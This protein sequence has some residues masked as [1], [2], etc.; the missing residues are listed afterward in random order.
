M[1][2]GLGT[3][4]LSRQKHLPGAGA[5]A[6]T[7][8]PVI[9]GTRRLGEELTITP[10]IWTLN[11]VLTYQWRR[12]GVNIDGATGLTYIA[13]MADVGTVIDALEIPNGDTG[14]AAVTNSLVFSAFLD[15]VVPNVEFH[16][17]ATKTASYPGTGQ[18]WAN[19]VAAP[20]SGA[21]QTA[22]DWWLG[23]DVN[24]AAADPTFIGS[25]GDPGAYF[26]LDGGDF[27]RSK[28]ATLP[29]FI[30]NLHKATG[31]QAATYIY[32]WRHADGS[33]KVMLANNTAPGVRGIRLQSTAAE[34]LEF[35]QRGDVANVVH[36]IGAL[37][38]GADYM[39][40]L[41]VPAGGGT[42]RHW[43]NAAAKTETTMTFDTTSSDPVG[44]ILAIGCETDL[45][46]PLPSGTQ[47]YAIAMIAGV[48]DDAEWAKIISYFE[49][50]TVGH[51]RNYVA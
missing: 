35:Q 17:D 39:V 51:N 27:F 22:Y 26:G 23:N 28:A 50:A 6:N 21:A 3:G 14:A 9:S 13:V 33:T 7:S 48:I 8:D 5:P 46:S 24:V 38:N 10:G 37:T 44:E 34:S 49:H 18:T 16:L 43:L 41:S 36:T 30:K 25:A 42:V 29:G 20:F 2:L 15:A 45:G 11:P 12:N 4:L 1:A 40:G 19:G 32:L 31:G 47:I